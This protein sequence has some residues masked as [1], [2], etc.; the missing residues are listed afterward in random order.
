MTPTLFILVLTFYAENSRF[1]AQAVPLPFTSQESCDAGGVAARKN[2]NGGAKVE[3]T[4]VP[5]GDAEAPQVST[6]K[7]DGGA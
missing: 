3:W 4:C 6:A 2:F 7:P 1:T 5:V